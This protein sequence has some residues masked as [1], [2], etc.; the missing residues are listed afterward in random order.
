MKVY[1]LACIFALLL[2][3]RQGMAQQAHWKN[4]ASYEARGPG[5]SVTLSEPERR[6]LNALLLSRAS[7]D[8]PDCLG[9]SNDTDWQEKLSITRV[10]LG[11]TRANL[12]EVGQGCARGGQGSNGAMWLVGWNGS[13]PHI[14]ASPQDGFDGWLYGVERA[15][16]HALKDVVVGWHMS[17]F[18]S[19][20]V[21]F[22][23]DGRRYRSIGD[24]TQYSRD[25]IGLERM[26]GMK[27][28]EH[29]KKPCGLVVRK[30]SVLAFSK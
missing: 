27:V 10:H 5:V 20:L 25:D 15:R 1:R 2:V 29:A 3:V 16:S 21:W 4:M 22:R 11:P 18:E 8:V 30:D 13:R 28:C 23:F 19:G 6:N 26:G 9:D 7:R 24:A 17:A 14:L 12:V